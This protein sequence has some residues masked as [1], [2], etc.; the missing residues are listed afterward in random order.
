MGDKSLEKETRRPS[1][2]LGDRHGECGLARL[3]QVASE[4]PATEIESFG[5]HCRRYVSAGKLLNLCGGHKLRD[6]SPIPSRSAEKIL[7]HHTADYRCFDPNT[8]G[9]RLPI[10]EEAFR[11]RFDIRHR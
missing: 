8:D 4:R 5:E 6:T 10:V 1:S 3:F 7:C 2:L 11:R 9:C